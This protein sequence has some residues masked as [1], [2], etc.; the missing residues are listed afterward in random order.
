V[1]SAARAA[2]ALPLMALA[3]GGCTVGPDFHEPTPWWSPASWISRAEPKTAVSEPVAEPIDAEWWKLFH[4]PQL[5]AL[6]RR[7][8]R[9][10]LDVRVAS[11]RLA[12]SRAQLG[13]ARAAEFP[14]LNGN[15]NYS[16]EAQS[17]NGVLALVPGSSGSPGTGS[18]GLGGTQTG[19]PVS[20]IA[21]GSSSSIATLSA[22]FNLYQY[23]FD[24]SWE[25]DLW[26][27]VRRSVESSSATVTAS[28]EAQ[29]G[30]LLTTLAELARDYIQLRGTQADIAT[31]QRNL[32]T[33]RQSLKLT[34]DRY[35]GGLTTE[36][37]V[38][39]AAAQV[40]TTQSLLPPLQQ[41]EAELINAISLLLGEQPK[42]LQ[43]ALATPKPIPPVPPRVPV[44]LPSELARR[45]PDIRQAEAQL[46]GATA[47]VGVAVADFYPSF[48]LSGSVALQGLKPKNLTDWASRTYAFG[49]S[50][51][52]PIFE[53]GRL[54][55]TLQLRSQEQQEAAINYQRTVLQA[56]HDV[57]NA[58]TAYNAE[59]RRR[60]QLAQAV[61][62]NR[63]ALE[64]AQQRYTQG[65]I[66]FL[67]VLDTER[68]LLSTE[69]QLD[70]STT[71]VST[72]LVQLYKALGG[73]WESDFPLHP[74]RRAAL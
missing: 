2:A 39:N 49:P 74:P 57:D 6:E 19:V 53:G 42:A 72:N 46:H 52:L 40:A 71:N 7:V 51:T 69:L 60:S 47:D 27:R 24:A 35:A 12:E 34:Q 66:D 63:R 56:L 22:P 54:R 1:Y 32:Q 29:R 20:G 18:N 23:G 16:R 4:D 26:G 3:M 73:G 64:L 68:N 41:R 38:A 15:A 17:A 36:L 11:I 30:T 50:I 37:D 9:S 65:V 14:T 28:E 10:N 5:T 48:S 61:A 62:H 59:Q 67:T 55:S 13:I 33:A 43:T 25:L 58:L 31:D 8:T 45:R 21:G 44:G 70:D